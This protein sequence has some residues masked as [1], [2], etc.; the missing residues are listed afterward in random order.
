[1]LHLLCLWTVELFILWGTVTG[2][3]ST[4]LVFTQPTQPN[5][6]HI[7][8]RTHIPRRPSSNDIFSGRTSVWD[9]WWEEYSLWH[10]SCSSDTVAFLWWALQNYN[11]EL[12]CKVI[13]QSR[14]SISYHRDFSIKYLNISSLPKLFLSTAIKGFFSW[15][16]L[17]LYILKVSS[18]PCI[19]VGCLCF[20]GI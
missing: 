17:K 7:L 12:L 20:E 19:L 18:P 8:K 6:Y 9:E 11:S 2:Q 13:W 5:N 16:S 10:C 3:A 15:Q 14:N 1:M 4:F